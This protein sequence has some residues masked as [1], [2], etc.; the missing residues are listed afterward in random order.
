MQGLWQQVRGDGRGSGLSVMPV[1]EGRKNIT[2]KAW[3]SHN[4]IMND[5]FGAKHDSY[6]Y[7]G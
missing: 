7:L 2:Y 4:G 5:A 3:G 1:G 6:R